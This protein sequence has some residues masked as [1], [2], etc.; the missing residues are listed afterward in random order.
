MKKLSLLSLLVSLWVLHSFAQKDVV[1]SG[2]NAVSSTVCSNGYVYVTGLNK[3]QAGVGVLGVGSS[4]DVETSWERVTFPVDALGRTIPIDQVNS[5]SGNH[6]IALDCYGQVWG[7]GENIYGQIG[8]GSD[9]PAIV[10]APAQ[11][12]LGTGSPLMGTV[13]DDGYGNLA[14]VDV[15]YAGNANSFAILGEGPYQGR[16]VAWGGNLE[17]NDYT[18]CLGTGSDAQA[19]NPTFCKDLQGNYM[20]DA[21][22]I[23]SGDHS[24]MIL[25]SDGTVWTCGDATYY[26]LGRDVNGG[27]FTTN[28]GA[29]NAFGAVYV[30][31]GQMLSG[32][33]EIACG[34]A[35]YFAL[36]E[37]GYVWSWGNDAWNSCGGTGTNGNGVPT[38]VL[39]GATYNDDND[40]T[41][42]LAK[43]IDAG[44]SIGMAVTI[45][46]RPVAWGGGGCAGGYVGDGGEIARQTPVYVR[47]GSIVHS[48]VILINRGDTY[49]FYER[50]DGSMYAWGCNEYGQLGIGSTN[51]QRYAV[52]INPPIGCEFRDPVPMAALNLGSMKV[53]ASNF[54]GVQLDCGFA[55]DATLADNYKITWYKDGQ[56]ITAA[57]GNGTKTSYTTPNGASGI[58]TYKV[59]VEYVGSNSGCMQYKIAESEIEISAF[60]QEF[61]VVG[62]YYCGDEAKVKVTPFNNNS[63]A[64]YT[65]YANQAATTELAKSIGAEEITIDVS[66]VASNA[67]GTKTIYVRE[68]STATGYLIPGTQEQRT[69]SSTIT[70]DYFPSLGVEVT[71]PT[72]F[73][74]TSM[75]ISPVMQA[76]YQNGEKFDTREEALT[77]SLTIEGFVTVT[78]NV[79]GSKMS[80]G[81]LVADDSRVIKTIEHTIPYSYEAAAKDA[82]AV[83]DN[84]WQP[85]W[86]GDNYNLPME[87]V[88][89]PLDVTLEGGIYYFTFSVS[90]SGNM[91]NSV[92]RIYE[93]WGVLV[94]SVDNMNGSA[95]IYGADIKGSYNTNRFGPLFDFK[96][97]SGMGFCDVVSVN[98]L[99]SCPCSVPQDFS[100]NCS[101]A[102]LMTNDSIYICENRP[103]CTLSTDSWATSGNNFEYI[104]YKDGVPGAAMVANESADYAVSD[105]GEYKILVRDKDVPNV[106]ACQME[107]TVTVLL[108]PIPT[109]TV[110]G[111]GEYCEGEDIDNPITFTMTGEPRFRVYWEETKEGG[112]TTT[113]NKRSRDYTVELTP[114]TEVGEYTYTLK[115]V[116][117]DGN[118][119]NESV[120]GTATIT[121]KPI[122]SVALTS[123]PDPAEIYEGETVVLTAQSDYPGASFAWSGQESGSGA[124]KTLTSASQSGTYGVTAFLNGC[125][126]KSEY[127]T[128][129]INHASL[130]VIDFPENFTISEDEALS[131]IDLST[132][133]ITEAPSL[134][135]YSVQSSDKKIVYPVLVG[136]KLDFIQYG[137]GTAIIDVSASLGDKTIKK[138][139]T[140]TINPVTLPQTCDLS[141][142]PS[143]TNVSCF[144]G[145]DGKI[146]LSVSGGIEPYQYKWNTGRTSNGI[147]SVPAGEYS[148]LVRDSV[149]CTTT[150]TF[151]IEEPAEIVV[152]ENITNPTCGNSNGAISITVEG[153]TAPYTQRWY[154][155]NGNTIESLENLQGDV[156]EVVIVDKNSCK[157]R[158]TYALQESGAPAISLVAVGSSKC[159][160]ATGNCE[161]EISGG[162]QPY[163]VV[164]SDSTVVWNEN[165]R[166]ALLP[167]TYTVTVS[168]ETNCRSVF[169]VE[170]PTVPFRQPEIALVTVGEESGKNL[171]VWQKPET[172]VIDHYTIWREGDEYGKYDKLGTVPFSETSIYADPD[173]DIMVQSWRYKIS[174][175]DACGNESPL[176]KEHKT[177]HLQ[178]SRGLDG[179]VNLVWD[180]Y[181]GVEYASYLIY[182]QTKTKVELFK[183]VSA[184]LNRYTDM[185]PPTDVIG[186]FVA[187]QL[188]DTI[189]V[190]KPLKA[191]SGPF[192]IAISNIAELENYVDAIDEISENLAIVYAN[193]KNIIVNSTEQANVLVFDITGQLVAQQEAQQLTVVQVKTAGVYIVIVGENVYK[194]SVQ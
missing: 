98:L 114:P 129:T 75:Y 111:G 159:D 88:E 3:L 160:E 37:D 89:I 142:V 93:Y 59:T 145:E 157:L 24:T 126:S 158:K 171:V 155:G 40:G 60:E 133:F 62:A 104:W 84:K 80:N 73:L 139:F 134:I 175:T 132:Y 116:I 143:V 128:V 45:S 112:V 190:N 46:G 154:S 31:S 165:K 44:M 109:V 13:Y 41:Y 22:R 151:T 177:I 50:S 192:I 47:C 71:E 115:S 6:F 95:S 90:V 117:D 91:N 135:S 121:I 164:W 127:V 74:S 11:V 144:G 53:C 78:I 136:N 118:C 173:A 185:T 110:S 107:K 72:S 30:S 27:L 32:I 39:A 120:T 179:E 69:A 100:I 26:S 38:R 18:S 17:N 101:D 123:D 163:A 119:K 65:W 183:K 130:D 184:S 68:T 61:E 153:G 5:G 106:T 167:G 181:E 76:P 193:E 172:D 194:V 92:S 131:I 99:Q 113:K 97:K 108:N 125:S 83:S 48:D 64:E 25:K 14:G 29:S 54:S 4:A 174:A 12:K 169:N 146:E 180:C 178:K 52:K 161:I 138:S 67:N 96:L 187:V 63:T 49:G 87:L 10:T 94:G 58:G 16:V 141:V 149:G 55:V 166:P 162:V 33:K 19:L 77:Q 103:H 23:Y 191:E 186:Y 85:M 122:P 70:T 43:A 156:Y 51:T 86:N 28:S 57:S 152:T 148:V 147:Y 79:C 2:G 82:L 150:S 124:I 42:L 182:R 34:D 170:V 140:I 35:A 105:A 168:D 137:T 188:H 9:S 15:V 66:G 20:T 7:W 21:I 176:S 81:N 36:D 1:I 56:K 8:I 102:S 189:D